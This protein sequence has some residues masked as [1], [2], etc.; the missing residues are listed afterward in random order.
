M[1]SFIQELISAKL[2]YETKLATLEEM[3]FHLF[4]DEDIDD[5]EFDWYDSSICINLSK[6]Y[7][8]EKFIQLFDM[9]LEKIHIKKTA[10]FET[11]SKD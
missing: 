1:A 3:V 4:P 7:P 8:K 9:G 2:S 5:I 11:I 10:I 6:S